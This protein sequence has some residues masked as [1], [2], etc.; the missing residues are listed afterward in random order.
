MTNSADPNVWNLA[1]AG[2]PR[3]NANA[4]IK[5]EKIE[6]QLS[7]LMFTHLIILCFYRF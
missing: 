4:Q 2:N 5:I 6:K 3:I 1:W 7:L